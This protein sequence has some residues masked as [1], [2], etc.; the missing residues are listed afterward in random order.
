VLHLHGIPGVVGGV[1]SGVVAAAVPDGRYAGQLNGVTSQAAAQ[2]LGLF[3]TFCECPRG[4]RHRNRRQ[5]YVQRV[6]VVAVFSGLITGYTLRLLPAMPASQL[7]LDDLEWAVPEEGAVKDAYN[8]ADD[9]MGLDF[10]LHDPTRP[11]QT[12]KG[13]NGACTTLT[14]GT[15][16]CV[17]GAQL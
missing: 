3:I 7:F 6:A 15:E 1:I 14:N 5:A 16:M 9:A 2:F 8:L 13:E 17:L 10:S 11:P 4:V 12:L